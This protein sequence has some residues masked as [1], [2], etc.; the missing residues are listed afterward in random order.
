[1]GHQLQQ[2]TPLPLDKTVAKLQ[3]IS[4]IL[5]MKIGYIQYFFHWEVIIGVDNV[6]AP[7]RWLAIT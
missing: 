2:L 4:A 6:L 7:N 3:A 1:M 5:S